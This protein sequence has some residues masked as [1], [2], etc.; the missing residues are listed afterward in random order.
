VQHQPVQRGAQ[1]AER[2]PVGTGQRH[3]HP[4]PALI[5]EPD[6]G[7]QRGE[8]PAGHPGHLPAQAHRHRPVPAGRL[9][10]PDAH[11]PGRTGYHAQRPDPEQVL[12]PALVHAPGH[13][14]QEAAAGHRSQA[15]SGS[16]EADGQ[17]SLIGGEHAPRQPSPAPGTQ[18]PKFAMS[19]RWS[20]R[21]RTR[22]G[23]RRSPPRGAGRQ[24]PG[25]ALASAGARFVGNLR[26][27]RIG[28]RTLV[29][30]GD[31]DTMVDPA[32]PVS[33]RTGSRSPSWP[34]SPGLGTCFSGRIRLGSRQ[35]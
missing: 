19:R 32:M 25:D 16:I 10:E 18:G 15:R 34:S 22:P 6:I 35:R 31:Q 14:A 28:A 12:H 13:L 7:I 3:A 33:W 9:G 30:H 2:R 21:T 27:R 1:G 5:A 17:H 4:A 11:Q 26:Q 29:I 23:T 8:Q 20:R 24:R